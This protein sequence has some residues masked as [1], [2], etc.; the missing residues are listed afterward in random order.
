MR[1]TNVIST[2]LPKNPN[3]YDNAMSF[4]RNY[5]YLFIFKPT[6]FFLFSLGWLTQTF[7][8]YKRKMPNGFND[9]FCMNWIPLGSHYLKFY[10]WKKALYSSFPFSK[11]HFKM[12]QNKQISNL[13]YP[14]LNR[15]LLQW[16]SHKL[17]V[18]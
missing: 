18:F 2:M 6:T 16:K 1:N 12:L 7:N 9:I 14:S 15:S 4:R 11:M 8:H 3:M 10:F 17:L 5:Y 13:F